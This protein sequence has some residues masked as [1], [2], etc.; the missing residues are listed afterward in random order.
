M[1]ALYVFILI[2]VFAIVSGFILVCCWCRC[3]KQKA[4]GG[5]VREDPNQ[6]VVPAGVPD[7][8]RTPALLVHHHYMRSEYSLARE[9][10]C[11]YFPSWRQD[12][13]TEEIELGV[14]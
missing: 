7:W 11:R 14:V 6:F 3:K 2:I 4:A 13:P 8:V 1:T 10:T 12:G 9:A 5:G